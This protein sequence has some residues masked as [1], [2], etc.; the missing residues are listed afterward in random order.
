MSGKAGRTE[1]PDGY[2]NECFTAWYAAGHP[3]LTVDNIEKI[4]PKHNG[5]R[6]TDITIREWAHDFQWR[7]QA[8]EMDKKALAIVQEDLIA[9]KVEVLRQQFEDAQKLKKV[10]LDFLVT[11]K[12]FDSSASAVQA[13]FKAAE[14][15][16]NSIGLAEALAELSKLTKQQLNKRLE[17]LLSRVNAEDA[18]IVEITENTQEES[19]K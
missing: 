17:D 18:E 5:H 8:N 15:E 6:P 1:Y 7:E 10:A 2:K 3:S 14:Q 16:R 19:P 9:K 13:Y 12:G 11:P 4:I